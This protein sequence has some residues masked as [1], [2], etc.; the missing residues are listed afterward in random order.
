MDVLKPQLTLY[1]TDSGRIVVFAPFHYQDEND[2][3]HNTT[4]TFASLPRTCRRIYSETSMLLYQRSTFVFGG[5]YSHF[6]PGAFKGPPQ[7]ALHK[8]SAMQLS[9]IRIVQPLMLENGRDNFKEMYFPNLKTV[10]V[11][12]EKRRVHSRTAKRIQ[13]TTIAEEWVRKTQGNEVDVVFKDF[14]SERVRYY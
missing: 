7:V 12:R 10:V 11:V 8:P 4:R 2:S 14:V 6:S 9:S 3:S 5:A 1:D 13:K